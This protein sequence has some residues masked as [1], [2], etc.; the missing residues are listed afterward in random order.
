VEAKMIDKKIGNKVKKSYMLIEDDE[1]WKVL[2]DRGLHSLIGYDG[3]AVQ[4]SFSSAVTAKFSSG[5][6]GIVDGE[7]LKEATES[8]IDDGYKPS[9]I[10]K[11]NLRQEIVAD[12]R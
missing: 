5:V 11:M 10:K 1:G 2:T 4:I 3:E 6:R 7:S 9:E 8:L 12:V